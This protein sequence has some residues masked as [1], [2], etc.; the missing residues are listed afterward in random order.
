MS[1]PPS[2]ELIARVAAA[3]ETGSYMVCLT[4]CWSCMF[5]ECP[6]GPHTWADLD[7][8][9]AALEHGKADPSTSSCGCP[10]VKDEPRADAVEVEY[11][12]G[13]GEIQLS[14][15][16]CRECGE[17]GACAWDAEGRP[18]I[19]ANGAEDGLTA[20]ERQAF[21]DDAEQDWRSQGGD[22]P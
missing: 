14:A 5:G 19:H 6:G 9:A 3:V 12:D 7:D 21:I 17:V 4:K 15:E 1:M 18:L 16:P 8:I 20:D 13:A 10:C 11:L 2:Q 22:Q